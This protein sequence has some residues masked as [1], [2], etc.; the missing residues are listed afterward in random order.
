MRSW[1]ATTAVVTKLIMNIGQAKWK[2][3][4]VSGL[5]DSLQFLLV[6][7]VPLCSGGFF[8]ELQTTGTS[9][10][11]LFAVEGCRACKEF[12]LA[13]RAGLWS[14]LFCLWQR[15]KKNECS[16]LLVKRKDLAV[17]C[18]N[19]Y[20]GQFILTLLIYGRRKN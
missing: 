4:F 1:A 15:G 11:L 16:F 9:Y 6:K 7:N 13:F 20:L 10:E 5:T 12:S 17:I 8:P 3:H 14:S 19:S 2:L 18:N